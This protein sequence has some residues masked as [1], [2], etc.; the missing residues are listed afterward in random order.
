MGEAIAADNFFFGVRRAHNPHHLCSQP[1]V[2]GEAA[3]DATPN[4]GT[5]VCGNHVWYVQ[6]GRREGDPASQSGCP[7]AAV[8]PAHIAAAFLAA[9]TMSSE[10][11]TVWALS[12]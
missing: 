7:R 4:Y 3:G 9:S 10:S 5:T 2:A 1:R 6:H 8:A 12:V 11:E